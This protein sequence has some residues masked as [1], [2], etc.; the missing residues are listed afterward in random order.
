MHESRR[1]DM[2]HSGVTGKTTSILLIYNYRTSTIS[3]NEILYKKTTRKQ[4]E[5]N[6]NT[7]MEWYFAHENMVNKRIDCGFS[8]K[9]Y[10]KSSRQQLPMNSHMSP[11][12]RNNSCFSVVF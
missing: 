7:T 2:L 4:L 9:K 3:A 1:A 8:M 5:N 12:L 11:K 10:S 6:L